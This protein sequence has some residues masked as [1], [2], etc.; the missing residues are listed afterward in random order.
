[1]NDYTELDGALRSSVPEPTM[2]PALHASIMSAVRA[3]GSSASPP[4]TAP[5]HRWLAVSA[6]AALV[7]AIWIWH[8]VSKPPPARSAF[9]RA[10]MALATSQEMAR[11]MPDT[12]LGPLTDE[13]QRL[14]QD[15]DN[16]AQFLLATLP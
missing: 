11:T 5:A 7:S 9:E 15:F 2:P 12:A 8:A 6:V 4:G 10:G 13:W 1:M 16:T 3:A 14:N